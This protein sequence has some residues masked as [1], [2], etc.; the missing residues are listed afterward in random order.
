M[1]FLKRVDGGIYNKGK[2]DSVSDLE[3][4]P[5]DM[6]RNAGALV[7]RKQPRMESSTDAASEHPG[8]SEETGNYK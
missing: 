7:K 6:E 3:K 4:Q 8:C 5:G 1:P 2:C